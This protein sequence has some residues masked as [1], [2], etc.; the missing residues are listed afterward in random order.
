MGYH[1]SNCA[2]MVA[3]SSNCAT[4]HTLRQ[5]G[6]LECTSNL[7]GPTNGSVPTPPVVSFPWD[8]DYSSRAQRV[9]FDPAQ[10]RSRE[11]IRGAESSVKVEV[12]NGSA[13]APALAMSRCRV[14]L[15]AENKRREG[16]LHLPPVGVPS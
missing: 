7:D 8:R 10:K 4:K 14:L 5:C 13:L 9:T 16:S 11:C 2:T 3:N 6:G 12:R 15:V 1:G